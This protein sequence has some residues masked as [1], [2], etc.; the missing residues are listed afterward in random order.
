MAERSSG[1]ELQLALL[2]TPVRTDE[3]ALLMVADTFRLLLSLTIICFAAVSVVWAMYAGVTLMPDTL[4]NYAVFIIFFICLFLLAIT[5]GLH[6]SAV[7][8]A[9][10]DYKQY[11]STHSR[12]A[13]IM[14]YQNEG[15]NLQV[16]PFLNIRAVHMMKYPLCD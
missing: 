5:E 15:R 3:G 9:Y 11:L 2:I 10:Q 4:P 14:K 8:V 7:Q 13:A 12:A 6:V 16:E 1:H